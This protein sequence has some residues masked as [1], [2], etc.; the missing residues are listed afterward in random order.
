MELLLRSRREGI[1]RSL[2]TRLRRPLL[3][4]TLE[5]S[6]TEELPAIGAPKRARRYSSKQK[7]VLAWTSQ[8]HQTNTLQADL[9]DLSD[10]TPFRPSAES[11][12]VQN[13]A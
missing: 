2:R 6:E 5:M 1:S 3:R 7:A 8:T 13:M 10:L 11:R 4:G 9:S 12:G